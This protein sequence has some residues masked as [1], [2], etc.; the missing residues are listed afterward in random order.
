MKK[1]HPVVKMVAAHVGQWFKC[2]TCGRVPGWRNSR[3]TPRCNGVRLHWPS[4]WEPIPAEWRIATDPVP[5]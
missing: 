4:G 5:K 2:P 1:P 3:Q